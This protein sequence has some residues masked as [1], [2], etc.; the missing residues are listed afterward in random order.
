MRLLAFQ[1]Y[2]KKKLT[3]RLEFFTVFSKGAVSVALVN[4]GE[5]Q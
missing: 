4:D 2:V 1:L 5:Y 3:D